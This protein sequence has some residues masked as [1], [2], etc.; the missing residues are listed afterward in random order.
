MVNIDP[1]VCINL[2]T[3][4]HSNL[5]RFHLNFVVIDSKENIK[6]EDLDSVYPISS[7]FKKI[8]VIVMLISWKF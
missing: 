3:F 8:A 5:R 7:F 6:E 1:N 4:E 2:P